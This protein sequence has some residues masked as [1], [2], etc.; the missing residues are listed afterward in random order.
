[1]INLRFVDFFA[2]IGG[3]RLGLES[4]GFECVGHCEIDKYA[5]KSYRAIHRPKE[6][7]WYAGDIRSVRPEEIHDADIWAG[8]FPCQAFSVAGKRGGFEDT[9]GTLIYE[10][11]RLAAERKPKILIL[12]NVKGLLNHEKGRTFGVI[13]NSLGE[14]GYDVEWE[15]LNSK[16]FGVPQNRE[17]VFIVGHLGDG[18]RGKV[19]PL[20]P[21]GSEIVELQGEENGIKQVGNIHQNVRKRENPNTGRVYSPEGISPCLNTMQGGGLEPKIV[22]PTAQDRHGVMI[23]NPSLNDDGTVT[24]IDAHYYKGHGT[25]CNKMRALA[26]DGYRIRRLTPKECFRLQ[27]FP[28]WAYERAAEVV[29]NSQLYKQAGNAVTVNVVAAIAERIQRRRGW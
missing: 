18:S 19:F 28:D 27:G 25:R 13:L 10:I 29:S 6:N 22:I 14:L 23:Q 9:R 5:E 15:L 26:T 20:G 21:N 12:E 1:M 3:F 2:G 4:V 11:F 24:A 8:G 16:N 17:R 7:E